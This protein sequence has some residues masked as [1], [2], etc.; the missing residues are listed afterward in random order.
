VKAEGTTQCL[1]DT[2]DAAL[3]VG[4]FSPDNVS[5]EDAKGVRDGEAVTDGVGVARQHIVNDASSEPIGG[6]SSVSS[7][8]SHHQ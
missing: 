8:M 1:F 6:E 3:G 4:K 5:A 2:I 7:T